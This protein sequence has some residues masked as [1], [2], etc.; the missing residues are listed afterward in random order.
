LAIGAGGCGGE[1]ANG[2]GSDDSEAAAVEAQKAVTTFVD[3]DDCD[4]LTDRFISEG[5]PGADD[6][7]DARAACEASTNKGLR[8]G[9]YRVTSAKVDGDDAAT[10]VLALDAGGTRTYKVVETDGKW[11]LNGFS[12]KASTEKHKLGSAVPFRD[13]YELNGRSLEV[14]LSI[15]APSLQ[16]VA[17]P[18]Y[19]YQPEPGG[20]WWKLQASLR[21]DS[22]GEV[23][24]DNNDWALRDQ[25][26]QSFRGTVEF[27]PDLGSDTSSVAPGE[28]VKGFLTFNLGRGSKPVEVLYQPNVSP[29]KRITWLVP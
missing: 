17:A 16:K 19:A 10:V 3:S 8:K 2:G 1:D 22:S 26:G 27:K 24:V 23:M 29:G 11:L 21:S 12:E 15:S 28:T 9:E 4:Y 18:P 6:P 5:F 14:R 13:S 20:S 25:E 7:E